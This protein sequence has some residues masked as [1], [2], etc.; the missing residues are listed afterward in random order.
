MIFKNEDRK[1]YTVKEISLP[2]EGSRGTLESAGSY[3]FSDLRRLNFFISLAI[4]SSNPTNN[5]QSTLNQ[6]LQASVNSDSCTRNLQSQDDLILSGTPTNPDPIGLLRACG[7]RVH[8]LEEHISSLQTTCVKLLQDTHQ[9][10]TLLP[11]LLPGTINAKYNESVI[12]FELKELPTHFCDFCDEQTRI[13]NTLGKCWGYHN[14][15]N[16]DM[17][18]PCSVLHKQTGQIQPT[19]PIEDK[20]QI[21]VDSN[22][23]PNV[24]PVPSQTWFIY[25]RM[26]FDAA[27]SHKS[28]I[29][30]QSHHS[31]IIGSFVTGGPDW[32]WNVQYGSSQTGTIV[33]RAETPGWVKVKWHTGSDGSAPITNTYRMDADGKHD[34]CYIDS[35]DSRIPLSVLQ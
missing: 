32:R 3:T 5:S 4:Q 23:I 27:I 20:N 24:V 7:N 13:P 35:N 2:Q 26:E 29:V 12:S 16:I 9:W 14:E 21:D 22:R 33:S 15:D 25:K 10:N 17:C 1:T 28:G 31:N 34:L 6:I 19:Q 30:V 11:L 18:L 8:Q